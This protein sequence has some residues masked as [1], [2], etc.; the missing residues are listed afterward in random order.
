M[1]MM[2]SERARTELV[3]IRNSIARTV[4]QTEAAIK[5]LVRNDAKLKKLKQTE[6]RWDSH[7]KKVSAEE[8]EAAN[9]AKAARAAKR[10]SAP[11]IDKTLTLG[12]LGPLPE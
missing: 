1:K 8:L 6:R 5:T 12:V 4:A 9:A 2:K 7:L 11:K 10:K 3:Q